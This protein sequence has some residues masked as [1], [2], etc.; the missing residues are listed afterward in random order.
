MMLLHAIMSRYVL[1]SDLFDKLKETEA[2]VG[3]EIQLTDALSKLDSIYRLDF[4][5]KTYGMG[6]R[7]DWLKTSIEFAM[8]DKESKDELI[9]FMKT[10][11][12]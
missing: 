12:D 10:Y 4:D 3:D 11:M 9:E 8:D 7:L 1:T 6:N 5:G 2:S